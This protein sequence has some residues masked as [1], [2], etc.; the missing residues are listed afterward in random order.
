MEHGDRLVRLLLKKMTHTPDLVDFNLGAND[1][2]LFMKS[3]FVKRHS[4]I[5]K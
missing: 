4:F 1:L 5:E 2:V 3:C